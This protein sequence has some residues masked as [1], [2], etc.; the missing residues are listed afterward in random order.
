M[1]N[2]QYLLISTQLA[3]VFTMK[4]L[5]RSIEKIKEKLLIMLQVRKNFLHILKRPY[6]QHEEFDRMINMFSMQ[7][8]D[9]LFA[10]EFT[11]DTWRG[12]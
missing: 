3:N 12:Q 9:Y 1:R 7:S 5:I 10:I 8:K 11:L 6:K 2:N 4:F